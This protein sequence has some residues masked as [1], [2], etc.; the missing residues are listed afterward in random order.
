VKLLS[1]I[2]GLVLLGAPTVSA[3]NMSCQPPS[4]KSAKLRARAID[5]AASPDYAE[6]R[7]EYHIANL[8]PST[9]VVVTQDSICDA[10]TRAINSVSTTQHSSAFIVVRF[11]KM[12][13]AVDSQGAYISAVYILDDKARVQTVFVG[14]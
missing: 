3:Q 8:D 14:T 2:I 6:F 13:A 7:T 1:L 12:Y 5:Y 10:V 11:G 9:V 4:D